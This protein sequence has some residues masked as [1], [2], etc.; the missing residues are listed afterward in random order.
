MINIFQTTL[1]GIRRCP[2]PASALLGGAMKALCAL[3]VLACQGALAQAPTLA[4]E[5]AP[6]AMPQIVERLQS[7]AEVLLLPDRG[8]SGSKLFECLAARLPGFPIPSLHEIVRETQ[9]KLLRVV[10]DTYYVPAVFLSTPCEEPSMVAFLDQLDV[11][12]G[13]HWLPILR[14]ERSAP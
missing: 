7:G 12:S 4:E 1:F 2:I 8:R 6:P 10:Y 9:T 13:A 11:P 14:R 3:A 5:M